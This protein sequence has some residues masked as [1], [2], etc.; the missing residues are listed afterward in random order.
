[1]K[2]PDAREMAD[3]ESLDTLVDFGKHCLSSRRMQAAGGSNSML[4]LGLF[5]EALLVLVDEGAGAT[6]ALTGVVENDNDAVASAATGKLLFLIDSAS[7]VIA[8]IAVVLLL[9]SAMVLKKVEGFLAVVCPHNAKMRDSGVLT[10]WDVRRTDNGFASALST[11][12][13]TSGDGGD[14]SLSSLASCF[15]CVVLHRQ[16]RAASMASSL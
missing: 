5:G 1:M 6:V 2:I 9:S 8:V 12:G 13:G 10:V 16:P 15:S 4:V 3:K 11:R 14:T 7:A